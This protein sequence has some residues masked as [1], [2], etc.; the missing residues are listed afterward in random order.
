[1]AGQSV[2]LCDDLWGKVK[3]AFCVDPPLVGQAG[4][5]LYV[6]AKIWA[7]RLTI[8]RLQD[9]AEVSI[10]A[11]QILEYE[12]DVTPGDKYKGTLRLRGPLA[13]SLGVAY[14]IIRRGA[15]DTIRT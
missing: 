6:A 11:K 12:A 8:R 1:M 4:G 15:H 9:G 2:N 3:G 7:S 13:V 5:D 10:N 14:P